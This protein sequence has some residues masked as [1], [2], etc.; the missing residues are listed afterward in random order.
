MD[1]GSAFRKRIAW[2]YIDARDLGQIVDLCVAKDGL[3]YQVFNAANDDTSSALT[4][5]ELLDASIRGAGEAEARQ[6]RVALFQ[7][8]DQEGARLQGT[9]QL[10]QIRAEESSDAL[11]FTFDEAR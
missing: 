1:Q 11:A 2:S 6:I 8:Q 9:A 4:T 5:Q 3:G 7:P 10:A